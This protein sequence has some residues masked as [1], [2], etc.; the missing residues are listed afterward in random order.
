M[1]SFTRRSSPASNVLPEP[2][3]CVL[4]CTAGS[5]APQ[6]GYSKAARAYADSRI[7]GS[8]IATSIHARP[9]KRILASLDRGFVAMGRQHEHRRLIRDAQNNAATT[10]ERVSHLVRIDVPNASEAPSAGGNVR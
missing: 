7:A 4:S 8:R 2:T 3:P 1:A 6:R 5:S 10:T 9:H